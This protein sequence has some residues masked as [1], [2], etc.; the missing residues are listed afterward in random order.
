M[1][2][3]VKEPKKSSK[4][5][6]FNST[7]FVVR[8]GSPYY[9]KD[10]QNQLFKKGFTWEDGTRGLRR[11]HDYQNYG[12]KYLYEALVDLTTKKISPYDSRFKTPGPR[13]LTLDIGCYS[14]GDFFKKSISKDSI[15]LED[16]MD[17][18][19]PIGILNDPTIICPF[20]FEDIGNEENE[21]R[22][23]RFDQLWKDLLAVSVKHM[24][25]LLKNP[26]KLAYIYWKYDRLLNSCR[27]IGQGGENPKYPISDIEEEAVEKY[28]KEI[29]GIIYDAWGFSVS[30]EGFPFDDNDVTDERVTNKVYYLQ[31]KPH[32][33]LDEWIE[34]MT[35][36]EYK[37]LFGT[38]WKVKDYLLCTIGTGYG[39]DK[40]GFIREEGA[41]DETDTSMFSNAL[42]EGRPD[43]ELKK[44][45]DVIFES[46]D[47]KKLMAFKKEHVVRYRQR[48]ET[49]KKTSG[50]IHDYLKKLKNR[51][52]KKIAKGEKVDDATKELLDII[53]S[54][55][56]EKQREHYP[57]C[58][59]SLMVKMPTNAHE[60]YIKA[61]IEIAHEIIVN[62]KERAE[63][64][65]EA[66]KVLKKWDKNYKP[67]VTYELVAAYP[68]NAPSKPGD[69]VIA[70][71]DG[72]PTEFY[73]CKVKGK[74][75]EY[76]KPYSDKT[77]TG[78]G[79]E[80]KESK[81]FYI[82]MKHQLKVLISVDELGNKSA[83]P[84][85]KWKSILNKMQKEADAKETAEVKK[86]KSAIRKFTAT[87]TK[88]ISVKD[89][90]SLKKDEIEQVMEVLKKQIVKTGSLKTDS[91]FTDVRKGEANLFGNKLNGVFSYIGRPQSPG[92]ARFIGTKYAPSEH[93]GLFLDSLSIYKL[94]DSRLV[95]EF[96]EDSGR[97][98]KECRLVAENIDALKDLQS[99][100][101]KLKV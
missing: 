63:S 84:V 4:K 35:H 54:K 21:E 29:E 77:E 26:K 49:A 5:D 16:T 71:P 70:T 75:S 10:T 19:R 46:E 39:W 85:S 80:S 96:S 92:N 23:C 95:I 100:L 67:T 27:Y 32:K 66:Q 51:I 7:Q 42:F 17:G 15:K 59:Y 31:S 78:V 99:F 22:E 69:D 83:V 1:A 53:S 56:E 57:I 2:E 20:T 36:K 58:D 73:I 52:L 8:F 97:E 93:S 34:L 55:E 86:N 82:K 41:S 87:E 3:T 61:A 28:G 30:N 94:K 79:L 14:D 13:L 9:Q 91:G 50:K 98:D 64:R 38:P 89:Y 81:P 45:L 44:D 11:N 47:Y 76:C 60:S 101:F 72:C 40:K 33:T 6:N 43:G 88:S 18:F 74:E 62:P 12:K 90:V 68:K 25:Y 24:E 37:S 48:D 65:K